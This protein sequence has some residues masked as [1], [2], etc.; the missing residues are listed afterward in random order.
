MGADT[1]DTV[2]AEGS[3]EHALFKALDL[4]RGAFEPPKIDPAS[5]A[6]VVKERYSETGRAPKFS[7]AARFDKGVHGGLNYV[8]LVWP[9]RTPEPKTLACSLI[10]TYLHASILAFFCAL[11]IPCY[12][13]AS[14]GRAPM[15]RPWPAL[16]NAHAACIHPCTR[17]CFLACIVACVQPS[18]LVIHMQVTEEL[19]HGLPQERFVAMLNEA[20]APITGDALRVFARISVAKDFH[21]KNSCDRKQYSVITLALTRPQPA[22]ALPI[23]SVAMTPVAG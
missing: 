1:S 5:G 6:P 15:A 3:A 8:S 2:Y 9:A 23:S 13:H 7:R 18:T 19:P 16:R 22:S 12:P 11:C 10:P 21:A 4:V 17:A 14:S 20:L